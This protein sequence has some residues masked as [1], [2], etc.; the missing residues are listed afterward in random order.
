MPVVSVQLKGI[1]INRGDFS[2]KTII[3]NINNNVVVTD[4]REE[5]FNI[6]EVKKALIFTFSFKSD[7][8]LENQKDKNFGTL[9]L[10]GDVVYINDEKTVK[11]ILLQWKKSK[12]IKD[13]ILVEVLQSAFEMAKVDAIYLSKKVLLPSPIELPNIKPPAQGQGYI[14]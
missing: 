3:K 14:G 2:D 1:N 4:I 13:S 8:K 5:K 7:Y 6:G 12:K 9:E 11:T 10:I